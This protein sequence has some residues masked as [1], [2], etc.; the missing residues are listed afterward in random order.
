M[1]I[2]MFLIIGLTNLTRL[3]QT[4]PGLLLQT[5]VAMAVGGAVY[6]GVSSLFRVPELVEITTAVRARLRRERA[7]P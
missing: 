1:G 4:K 2:A 3:E 5:A 7:G 6:L